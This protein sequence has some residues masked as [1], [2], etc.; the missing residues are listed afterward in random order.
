MITLLEGTPERLHGHCA[1]FVAQGDDRLALAPPYDARPWAGIHRLVG[2]LRA[3][4]GD[5]VAGLLEADPAAAYLGLGAGPEGLGR[6]LTDAEARDAGQLGASRLSHL[7]HNLLVQH[8]L[9]E[10]WAVLLRDLCA[11]PETCTLVVPDLSLLDRESLTAL[12]RLIRRFPDAAPDLV[13]GFDP[14]AEEEQP[15]ADGLTWKLPPHD[16]LRL[17]LGLRTLDTTRVETLSAGTEVAVTTPGR[18]LDGDGVTDLPAVEALAG[19]RDAFA[20]FAFT[21]ALRWGLA[22]LDRV[23]E[24]TS[25]QLTGSQLAELHGIVALAAHN[26][27]F[28]SDGNLPL[29]HFL[30]RHL[31]ASWEHEQ[32]DL[33]AQRSATAYRLAV[34]LGRRLKQRSAAL[35]W[36]NRAIDEARRVASGHDARRAAHLEAWGRNIRAYLLMGLERVEEAVEDCRQAFALVA[37]QVGGDGVAQASP[38]ATSEDPLLRELAYTRSLL[39][40]NLGALLL[41]RGGEGAVEEAAEWKRRSDELA[42][43]VPSLVRFENRAWLVLYREQLRLSA[44]LPKALEGAAAAQQDQDALRWLHYTVHAADLEYRLGHAENAYE[45]FTEASALRGQ[46]GDPPFLRDL[47]LFRA[48]AAR[49][50]G[51]Q[52]VAAALLDDLL[53]RCTRVDDAS[54]R[55]ERTQLLALRGEIDALRSKAT[56]AQTWLNDAIESALEDGVRDTML[57]VALAVA[58]SNRYLGEHDDSAQAYAQ[59]LELTVFGEDAASHQE[60]HPALR[61]EAVIGYLDSHSEL[62]EES[63]QALCRRALACLPDALDDADSWWLL[64]PLL[65][66]LLLVGLSLPG[67]ISFTRQRGEGDLEAQVSTLRRAAAQREDCA[68]LLRSFEAE[69]E[70]R[71]LHFQTSEPS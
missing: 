13:A 54:V 64:A 9:F 63:R 36:A 69:P 40:D 20:G 33:A 32:D 41:L 55:D 26:R 57:S 6:P 2:W 52:A 58:R 56:Q 67:Q 28:R 23:E 45:H 25:T 50:A 22:L 19:V 39:A 3:R 31:L 51:R 10:R 37:T 48:A 29:G 11:L 5:A 30:E 15:D 16:V 62:D 38:A 18:Q 12:R 7:S 35:E 21:A 44:A 47:I 60:A 4:H 17:V 24:Q 71:V 68:H 1:E 66:Q 14:R 65:H 53:G 49:R 43:H 34:V 61:F 70:S 27:Q 42:E 59:A 8:A 46:L